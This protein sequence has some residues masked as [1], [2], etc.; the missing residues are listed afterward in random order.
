ML[1]VPTDDTE[2]ELMITK[3]G[4]QTTQTIHVIA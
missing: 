4:D 1:A 3:S 2:A